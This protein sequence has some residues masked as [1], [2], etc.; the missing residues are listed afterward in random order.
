MEDIEV[1]SKNFL[2][3]WVN[4]E[5]GGKISWR[6]VPAKRSINFG[7]FA[8]NFDGLDGSSV[9][10]KFSLAPGSLT[11]RLEALGFVPI[12]A[13][14]SFVRIDSKLPI[15]ESA[16]VH[17]NQ[18]IAFIFDNTFSVSYSKHVQFTFSVVPPWPLKP[19]PPQRND[20]HKRALAAAAAS[21]AL[22]ANKPANGPTGPNGP[23]GYHGAKSASV[24]NAS[25][26][27]KGYRPSKSPIGSMDSKTPL[28]Q[29]SLSNQNRSRSRLNSLS[30]SQSPVV[31]SR[32]V[33]EIARASSL[34]SPSASKLNSL[35]SATSTTSSSSSQSQNS[36]S[37]TPSNTP[38]HK[39][40]PTSTNPS[41]SNLNNN[42]DHLGNAN[43]DNSKI[44]NGE[45]SSNLEHLDNFDNFENLNST[46]S[47]GSAGSAGSDGSDGSAGSDGSTGSAGVSRSKS[48]A[49]E[50]SDPAPQN[51][52]ASLMRKKYAGSSQLS[53]SS[54]Q[55]SLPFPP[56]VT[57]QGTSASIVSGASKSDS[58]SISSRKPHRRRSTLGSNHDTDLSI[59]VDG[60]YVT[61][62]LQKKRRKQFQ[63]FAKRYFS[64]DR[65]T[66][67]LSYYLNNRTSSLRGV[68][69]VKMASIDIHEKNHTITL[70][71][72]MEVW[73][74]KA[75]DT[76]TYE[77][78]RAELK[79]IK[80]N[81]AS[82]RYD[83]E[84]E[85]ETELETDHD[86]P[87]FH[88]YDHNAE[89]TKESTK[90][91]NT[92]V[93]EVVEKNVD[94]E[95]L[96]ENKCRKIAE[97][98]AE[99]P[100]SPQKTSIL[101]LADDL[102]K[103]LSTHYKLDHHVKTKHTKRHLHSHK[104]SLS[105][106]VT[107]TNR[108]PKPILGNAEQAVRNL[109]KDFV[110]LACICW[111]YQLQRDGFCFV[112]I[113][114]VTVIAAVLLVI[115]KLMELGSAADIAD[116]VFSRPT[117]TELKEIFLSISPE[118]PAPPPVIPELPP[119]PVQHLDVSR[120]DAGS[121]ETETII[122]TIEKVTSA[123][124]KDK[125]GKFFDIEDDV[126]DDSEIVTDLSA[127]SSL[128]PLPTAHV[129]RRKTVPKPKESPPSLMSMLKQ[130]KD[131]QNMTAPITA[132]EP[133]S[134]LENS[135]EMM[136]S[137][138]LLDA[139][140]RAVE[141]SVERIMLVATFAVSRLGSMRCRER[142]LRKPFTPLLGETYELVREDRGF[143]FVSEKVQHKPEVFATQAESSLWTL[144]FTS[145]PNTKMWAKSVQLTDVG[146]VSVTFP[147]GEVIKY[148][149]PEMFV[150][151]II[152]GE[153]YIEP[154][155]SVT[156]TSNRGL[157]AQIEF[158]SG[159]MFS[160]RSENLKISCGSTV[161]EGNWTEKISH[162]HHVIWKATPLVSDYANHYGWPVFVAQLNEITGL[163]KNNLPPNDSRLR[164]DLRLYEEQD[165]NNAQ[166]K[167][168]Y[169]E[170]EQRKRRKEL[171]DN[172]RTH[173]PVFF[174][175][176]KD[177]NG[178]FVLLQGDRN[179]WVRRKQG[180]WNNIP[181][182]FKS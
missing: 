115:K 45:S 178:N 113:F 147:D 26:G 78:W 9:T 154:N 97:V 152:V 37:S 140:A 11:E 22:Y 111:S 151:N 122:Q 161:Y 128:Y 156:V 182:Y 59:S 75:N 61:G 42:V 8:C 146:Q 89:V 117:V 157:Q 7:V 94:D 124:S 73:V 160:G 46:G 110:F 109:I 118:T 84:T 166:T 133:I 107:I 120:D 23:N 69:P 87:V 18:L 63:G 98:A 32:S 49:P 16:I 47:A 33:D 19:D 86:C 141:K 130:A 99:L 53:S 51:S 173:E 108:P 126:I 102:I 127:E 93:G 85:T 48:A 169:L 77:A 64:L 95:T 123:P 125:D 119:T 112:H 56:K 174:S 167:K 138:S 54:S 2:I 135:A 101:S 27:S 100:D 175:K 129:D 44:S 103:N 139:A 83:G 15:E 67:L 21:A 177:I 143:R 41:F 168:L 150:R 163:E 3:R 68:M 70:D 155:G 92:S 137:A 40:A 43:N 180:N 34:T 179:Y 149:N 144:H 74:L 13:S 170:Q 66:G 91:T 25:L 4:A 106:A 172:Q 165:I 96:I 134:A 55:P 57:R 114:T 176:N 79:S 5:H 65:K 162:N 76:I 116:F 80:S 132:N 38:T 28:Q 12:S 82:A 30:R 1:H 105:N 88:G 145:R 62:Y 153:R 35:T 72:G 90:H 159:G 81:I 17:G 148:Q 181:D 6:V 29:P 20:D 14:K 121:T 71:S 158:K 164:P 50:Y 60:R 58:E 31:S 104:R 142:V 24:S 136:D 39:S 52:S 10:K 171:A 36:G 131:P